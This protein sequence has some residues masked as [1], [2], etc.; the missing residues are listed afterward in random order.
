MTRILITGAGGFL[1][2]HLANSLLTEGNDLVCID[3]FSRIPKDKHVS[4]LMTNQQV[5]WYES[6][7]EELDLSEIFS[8]TF[9]YI[10]H[11]ATINGTDNF[12][13][14]PFEV[15]FSVV[16]P[17]LNLLREVSKQPVLPKRFFLAS[18]S[19]VYA[20]M[21]ELGVSTIPTSEN[22]P[23][24]IDDVVNPRWSYAAG[25]I[26]AESAVISAAEQ[27]GFDWL[28][29]RYHNVYGP[30]MGN[31]HFIPDFI[32]RLKQNKYFY[33]GADQT[34]CF[35]YISDAISQTINHMSQVNSA[36][37]IINIG[38]SNETQVR[39]VAKLILNLMNLEGQDCQEF[40]A[41]RG[42]VNRRVPNL[43]LAQ[44]ILG[45]FT[46]VPLEQGLRETI[47]WYEKYDF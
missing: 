46:F 41:L 2:Y 45:D 22:T 5:E 6:S 44:D 35:T 39:E 23:I 19:E 4:E 16:V 43:D 25:K 11:L 8:K 24:G 36:N 33:F 30:R 34:R 28:I 31:K 20:S 10:Y 12:Y 38:S 1:G 21:T 32:S 47:K 29:G 37:K 17:T 42:S 3:N 26:A 40:P 9:D 14:Q 13:S 7:I 18:T 27:Y 15:I